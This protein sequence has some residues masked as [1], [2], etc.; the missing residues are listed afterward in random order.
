MDLENSKNQTSTKI[1]NQIKLAKTIPSMRL[2]QL[3]HESLP[4]RWT[5]VQT[6]ISDHLFE[7]AHPRI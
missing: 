3:Q 5:L 4:M 2:Q 7:H 6:C 1:V